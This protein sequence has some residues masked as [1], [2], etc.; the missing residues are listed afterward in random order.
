VSGVQVIDRESYRLSVDGLVER[1]LSLS[2]ADLLALPQ[3]A[4]LM[5]LDC[6]EGWDFTAKWSGPPLKAL[7]ERAGV[8]PEAKI[9][10]FRTADV[11]DGYTSLDLTY[12]LE[13]NIIIALKIND[14]TLPP[15]RGFPI[16]VAAMSKYGYKWAKWV[17]GIELSDNTAFRGYWE[18]GGY[19]N[20]ADV[21]GPAFEKR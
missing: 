18:S 4:R 5:E 9:V 1:P 7:F 10:I 13:Y 12:I 20:S 11:P 2:Y 19:N 8:K 17:T 21:N 6:V 16:Q 14:I 3:E 15:E